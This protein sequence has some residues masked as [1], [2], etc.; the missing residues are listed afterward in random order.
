MNFEL[1]LGF[2]KKCTFSKLTAEELNIE[3]TAEDI[4]NHYKLM[5]ENIQITKQ[6]IFEHF[7]GKYPRKREK[8]LNE[9]TENCYNKFLTA[10]VYTSSDVFSHRM[11]SESTEV[12]VW[13]Q[14]EGITNDSI[15]NHAKEKQDALKAFKKS[16]KNPETLD[17]LQIKKERIGLSEKE[18]ELYDTLFSDNILEREE[19]EKKSS[20]NTTIEAID[21]VD[22]EAPIQSK[23]TKTGEDIW[24]VRFKER[25]EREQF[26]KVSDKIKNIGGYYSRF[27]SVRGF[28]FKE[29]PSELLQTLKNGGEIQKKEE[30]KTSSEKFYEL[31]DNMQSSIDEKFADRQTNTDRRARMAANAIAEG[32]KLKKLQTIIRNIAK[33]FDEGKIKYL[34]NINAK[35]H[36]ETLLYLLNQAHSARAMSLAEDKTKNDNYNRFTYFKEFEA[37]PLCL[38]DIPFVE[39]PYPSILIADIGELYELTS[40]IRGTKQKRAELFSILKEREKNS[41]NN[42]PYLK[43]KS[44][45]QYKLIKKLISCCKNDRGKEFFINGEDNYKRI[46]DTLGITCIEYL[47]TA[48]REFLNFLNGTEIDK[49]DLDNRKVKELEQSLARTKIPGFFPTPKNI[50]SQILQLAKI[51]EGESILEPSAGAGHIADEIKKNFSNNKLDVIELNNSLRELLEKK[52]YN[53]IAYDFLEFDSKK[54]D[55]IIMN[56]PF[57]KN[58][59]ITHMLHAYELLNEGGRLIAITSEHPFFAND[60]LSIKFRDFIDNTTDCYSEK[61]PE[62]SFLTSDRKTG[63]NTRIVYLSKPVKCSNVEE[64]NKL[65]TTTEKTNREALEYKVVKIAELINLP[66]KDL[67]KYYK[68]LSNQIEKESNPTLIKSH[69]MLRELILN[70]VHPL[71]TTYL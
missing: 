20:S 16:L 9:L 19:Q 17:E 47:R 45:Y 66:S 50:V 65:Q 62:G 36:V 64:E 55:V 27:P 41:E 48:L 10:L 43:I 71:Q 7:K 28:V 21:N 14:I 3:I 60:K 37:N 24:I 67:K 59:D 23:N 31:A 46:K 25:V 39:Y 15:K 52:G 54:Y 35:T 70:K 32:D 11:M 56:P 40:S 49:K 1:L 53:V 29:D 63:V 12:A 8:T 51:Q 34:K 26:K 38:E 6:V 42:S 2:W 44:E 61:L 58:L 33:G 30:I 4:R 18:Q 5:V 13:R 22:L 68:K 57:E 69:H